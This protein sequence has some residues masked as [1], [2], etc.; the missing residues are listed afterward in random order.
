[1]DN[2]GHYGNLLPNSV[3]DLASIYENDV[4]IHDTDA[5]FGNINHDH[6]RIF[7]DQ[8]D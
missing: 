1:V 8:S 5:Q 4:S 6:I 3:I 7:N 2:A